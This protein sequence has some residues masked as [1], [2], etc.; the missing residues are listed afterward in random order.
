M[1]NGLRTAT[2]NLIKKCR[3]GVFFL[4]GFFFFFAVVIFTVCSPGN[5]PG[6]EPRQHLNLCRNT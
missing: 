2:L 6:I 1:L 5:T 4:V 3:R